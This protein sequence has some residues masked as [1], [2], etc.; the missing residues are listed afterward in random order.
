MRHIIS[1]LF[2][3]FSTAGAL[4]QEAKPVELAPDAPDHH[5][6]VRGDTLWGISKMFLKDPYRWPEVWQLN[7]E[8]IKNPHRIY[9]GQVV[10]L[11]TSSGQPRLRLGKTVGDG[12]LQPKVYSE[13]QKQEIPAIPQQVI[14]P[15]LSEPLVVEEGELDA[16]PRV[17]ATEESHVSVGPTNKIYVKDIKEGTAKQWQIY[18]PGK[19][20]KDPDTKEVLGHE[21]IFV[22]TAKVLAEG[23]PLDPSVGGAT[24]EPSTLEVVSTKMEVSKGDSLMPAAHPDIQSYVPHAPSTTISGKIMSIYGG[25]GEAGRYSIVTVS[26]GKWDGVE[27][28]HVLAIYRTGELVTNHF[29]GQKAETVKLPDERYGLLFVFRVFDRVSYALIMETTRPV[30]AG[31]RAQ[32]P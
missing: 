27:Q 12:R 20:L 18:R 17:V 28:G 2:F 23:K 31:D 5:V 10:Y 9:P 30:V 19:V 21:A 7:T 13:D 1:A 3:C 8:Q 22:G 25:V 6:V 15:F 26:K 14:E 16:A 29:E 24:V 4:A 32:T 11:D